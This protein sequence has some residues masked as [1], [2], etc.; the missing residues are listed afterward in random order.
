MVQAICTRVMGVDSRE[1][2]SPYPRTVSNRFPGRPCV[3][4]GQPSVGVG[5]HVIPHWLIGDFADTGPFT[6]ERLDDQRVSIAY[7]NRKGCPATDTALPGVHVPMCTPCNGRSNTVIE[8]PARPVVRKIPRTDE[9][10]WPFLTAEEAGALGRW[11]L[12]VGVLLA[13]PDADHDNPHVQRDSDLKVR[14]RVFHPEW[15]S[16]IAAGVDPPADFSVYVSRVDDAPWTGDTQWIVL[17]RQLRV[18]GEEIH[19]M[20]RSFRVRDL[21]ATIVWHPGWPVRHPLV[22]AGRAVVLWPRPS[23]P[24]DLSALPPVHPR[25]VAF[26]Y[27]DIDSI[28]LSRAEYD[29]LARTPLSPGVIPVVEVARLW[30]E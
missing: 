16:W 22:E 5:E 19:F 12:K 2:R 6:T 18:G 27:D 9:G 7:M 21:Q 26:A 1:T 25:E 8:E 28:E 11:L 23:G 15:A 4:C 3:L 29:V 10:S 14:E 30:S 24:I 17:A 13:H 20:S